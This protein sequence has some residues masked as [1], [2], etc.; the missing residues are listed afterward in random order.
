MGAA[1]CRVVDAQHE[2]AWKGLLNT[3]IP[4]VDLSVSRDSSIQIVTVRQT[5]F[6]KLAVFRP[7]RLP[8]CLWE[9]DF[10]G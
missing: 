4:L 5:P 6:S 7:L 10:R 3:E 9:M 1:V 8:R 2:I